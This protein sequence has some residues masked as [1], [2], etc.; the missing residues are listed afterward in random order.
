MT[1]KSKQ[2]PAT[3]YIYILLFSMPVKLELFS[4]G[5][6]ENDVSMTF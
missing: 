5:S 2:K 4:G 1:Y 6:A 3:R